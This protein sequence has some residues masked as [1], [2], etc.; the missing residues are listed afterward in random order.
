MSVSVEKIENALSKIM[1]WF[2]EFAA[3]MLKWE[4]IS[5]EGLGTLA[6]NYELLL[7][8]P[9]FVQELSPNQLATGIIH[10]AVHDAMLHPTQLTEIQM[11]GRDPSLWR[12]AAEVVTN[13]ITLDL[14]RKTPF[15][16]PGGFYD[17]IRGERVSG[18]SNGPYVFLYAPEGHDHTVE[19]VYEILYKKWGSRASQRAS[20]CLNANNV[21]CVKDV[22]APSG[23]SESGQ[24]EREETGGDKEKASESSGGSQGSSWRDSTESVRIDD[25]T[26]VLA[27]IS[28]RLAGRVPVGVARLLQKLVRGRIPWQ[29]ILRRFVAEVQQGM[30]EPSWSSYDKKRQSEIL[31]PGLIERGI[32]ELIIA[33]DTSGSI[34]QRELQM[35]LSEVGRLLA[36]YTFQVRVY[37]VDADVQERVTVKNPRELVHRIKLKGGGGTNFTS[38]FQEVRQCKAMIFFTDGYATYPPTSPRY[39]VLWVLTK[40]HR[41]PPFGRVAYIVK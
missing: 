35:F 7:Y 31:L 11:S 3:L 21:A 29:R 40:D 27:A 41:R 32:D 4:I 8:D 25:A 14:I 5:Q 36:T 18:V 38:L 19:E 30:D 26:S 28:Q 22:L 15:S 1:V 17:P 9:K 24:K 20:E 39:P 16:F 2:P 10:E 23:R 34:T 13:A 37:T 12:V 33:I 6:T